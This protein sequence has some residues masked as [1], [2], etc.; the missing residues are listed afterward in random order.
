MDDKELREKI[1][2]IIAGFCWKDDFDG[3]YVT[4][5]D[6]KRCR[7]VADEILA[8]IEEANWGEL[9]PI[10]DMTN[11]Y[12]AWALSNGYVKLAD[13][14]YPQHCVDGGCNLNKVLKDWRKVKED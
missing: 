14:S 8:V 12:C 9:P 10:E 2:R 6:R 4:E 11:F 1:A 3:D 13:Q 5:H 7:E